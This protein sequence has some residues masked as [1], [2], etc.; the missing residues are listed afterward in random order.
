MNQPKQK[1]QLVS[2]AVFILV[3]PRIITSLE[4][5][6][7]DKAEPFLH[8]YRLSYCAIKRLEG[9]PQSNT[10]FFHKTGDL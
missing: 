4:T 1:L 6:I 8:G 9:A 10:E 5:R 3:P 2:S 7:K